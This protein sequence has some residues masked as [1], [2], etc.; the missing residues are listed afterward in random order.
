[1]AGLAGSGAQRSRRW[2]F[3]ALR[4]SG[5]G[6]GRALAQATRPG[7]PRRCEATEDRDKVMS[8]EGPKQ[9]NEPTKGPAPN[10]QPQQRPQTPP[11]PK[12]QPPKLAA[13]RARRRNGFLRWAQKPTAWFAVA[14]AILNLVQAGWKYKPDILIA[15]AASIDQADALG[16]EFSFTNTGILPLEN[17]TFGCLLKPNMRFENN[18]PGQQAVSKLPSRKTVTRNCSVHL[19]SGPFRLQ[20]DHPE[21]LRL[22]VYV[23][24][25]IPYV[26]WEMQSAADFSVR[27]SVGQSSYVLVPDY[28]G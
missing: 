3:R 5:Q 13:S 12:Q 7:H 15:P 22:Q 11:F 18:A 4:P 14:S 20:I 16:T 21:S 9:P 19:L 2:L 25:K 10:R 8:D 23:K 28:D 1:M 17:L 27:K 24:Y 26:G 6:V